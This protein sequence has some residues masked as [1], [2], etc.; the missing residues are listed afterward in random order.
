[1]K[2]IKVDNL[3]RGGEDPGRDDVLVASGITDEQLARD[4]CEA[5]NYKHS[6]ERAA[7]YFRVVPD[8]YRLAEFR[9]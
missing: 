3:G 2:I 7:H 4:M 1:M 8:D 9:P 5:L 6:G